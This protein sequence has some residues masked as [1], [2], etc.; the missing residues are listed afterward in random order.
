MKKNDNN[1]DKEKESQN[2]N[3]TK[4]FSQTKENN[5]IKN[6]LE[7]K[8]ND[9]K[10]LE[11]MDVKEGKN[12]NVN[13]N[14][15][16]DNSTE[17]KINEMKEKEIKTDIDKLI[18]NE[19]QNEIITENN[20]I[21]VIGDGEIKKRILK[22]GHGKNPKEGNKVIIS[23]IGKY[24]E[25]IIDYSNEQ[26]PFSFTIGENNDMKGL[27]IAV[28]TMKLGEKSKFLMTKEYALIDN[29]K[30]NENIPPNSIL[31]Y[32]IELKSIEYKNTEESLENLSYE[33]KLQWGQLLK[34]E[35][36]EKFKANEISEAKKCFL[37]ALTFLRNMDPK[38]DEEKEGVDLFLTVLANICNC[39]NKEKDFESVIKFAFIGINIR[40]TQKLLYFRTIAYANLEEFE[41]AEND[42]KDLI[43][44]FAI[45]GEENNQEV[46]DTVNIL[47]ELIDS[48]KKIF[49]EK[50]KK[51]SQA[52]YRKVFYNNKIMKENILVPS[53]KPNPENPVV[54][55]EIQIENN[56]IGKIEFELFKNIAPLTSENFRNLCL[57]TQD[58]L[59][60]KNSYFN[61]I[62]KDFVLGGGNI[63]NNNNENKCIYGQYF[64]DENYI[65]CHCRRGLLTM[66]ND[67]KNKNNCK[68]LITLKHIPWFDG[69]HVVFGQV[70]NGM[71]IIDQIENIETNNEDKP[72]KKI[73]IVNCG[74]VKKEG[75]V[76]NKI[77]NGNKIENNKE[78]NKIEI[79]DNVILDKK[80]ENKKEEIKG[81][82]NQINSN[83]LYQKEE[84][85][86]IEIMKEEGEN[87]TEENKKENI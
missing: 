42:L 2:N 62:I 48:R 69:K 56:I 19:E 22:E 31:E 85:K 16:K 41:N 83:N 75:N 87:K 86:N 25:E 70:I 23:Y 63:E 13:T 21:N 65:Y 40:A 77:I 58:G 82:L 71:E 14:E 60:Y 67:G 37:N 55:F 45:N 11:T 68:F 30:S 7:S 4:E 73:I 39:Y 32:D 1:N 20:Y 33:E 24:N 52:I 59:T 44:L 84:V 34:K 76:D 5:E 38:K 72:L 57:G 36:V 74:E 8:I 61:K 49:Q 28:K 27:E 17:N 66:D 3:E 26:E 79:E 46:N 43:D 10:N 81:N 6:N 64:D 54:F 35:G 51:Y 80:D 29:K 12:I 50:N 18:T 53:E 15:K 78:N 9:I 47:R